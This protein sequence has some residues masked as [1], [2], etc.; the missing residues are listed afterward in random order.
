MSEEQQVPI[1]P[2]L[3]TWPSPRPQLIGAKCPACGAVTFP[4][5]GSCPN[6]TGEMAEHLLPTTGRLWTWTIQGFLPPK[7][8]Y[9]GPETPET[10]VPYGVGYIELEGE[11]KVEARLTENDPAKLEIGMPVEMVIVAFRTDADGREVLTFA[12]EPKGA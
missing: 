6:C 4:R 3:F 2:G 5:Q 12:F 7:P 8:P 11:V 10:F 9:A 1:E